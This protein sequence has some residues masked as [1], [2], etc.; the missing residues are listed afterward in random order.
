MTDS[1]ISDDIA[2][3]VEKAREQFYAI[4]LER[5]EKVR[6]L[7]TAIKQD[8]RKKEQIQDLHQLYHRLAGSGGLYDMG[9]FCDRAIAAEDLSAQLGK[10]DLTTMMMTIDQLMRLTNNLYHLLMAYR[11]D[12]GVSQRS[13]T[14]TSHTTQESLEALKRTIFLVG[15]SAVA[16]TGIFKDLGF[17]TESA[18]DFA[19]ARAALFSKR[20]PDGLLIDTSVKGGSPLELARL[21]RQKPDSEDVPIVLVGEEGAFNEKITSIQAGCDDFW[22]SRAEL[23]VLA[24]KATRVFE[25][26]C[27]P[28]YKILV[29]ED[30]PVQAAAMHAFLDSAGFEP[31]VMT[32]PKLFEEGLLASQPDLILLDLI[33]G[34][35]SGFDLAKFVRQN[36]KFDTTPIVFLT[37]QNQLQN[38]VRGKRLGDDYLIKPATPELLVST[39]AGRIERYRAI[40]SLVG[41]D[42]LTGSLS[43][44]EFMNAA[45]RIKR[46]ASINPVMLVLDIDGLASINDRYSFSVGEKVISQIGDILKR[47]FREFGVVGRLS[48]DEFAVVADSLSV[49]ELLTLVKMIKDEFEKTNFKSEEG[50]FNAS[51]TF[52]VASLK[53]ERSVTEWLDVAYRA[54]A[55]AKRHGPGSIIVH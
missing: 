55:E 29:V 49:D 54:L 52:G 43:Y 9:D 3:T 6:N 45:T 13:G 25:R 33:L 50:I 24:A 35:M 21:V 34:E 53:A 27:T 38:Q 37:T 7:L 12:R 30:D 14:S 48:G 22:N 11:E 39:I 5:I 1:Y 41:R 4:S 46:T 23:E 8:P 17:K 19:A 47:T 51:I 18:Q 40:K 16:L 32:D 26:I 31:M 28:R 10:Q 15:N 20:L 44:A 36:D 2:R 42:G